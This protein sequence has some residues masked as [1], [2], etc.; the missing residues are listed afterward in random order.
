[1]SKNLALDSRNLIPDFGTGFFNLVPVN[2][3]YRIMVGYLLE[4]ITAALNKELL[5]L[6]RKFSL[7]PPWAEVEFSNDAEGFV[8]SLYW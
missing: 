1:M 3:I 6:R 8:I 4:N 7:K 2:T 5:C